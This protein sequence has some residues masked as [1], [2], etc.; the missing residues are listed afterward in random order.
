MRGDP[1]CGE[2]KLRRLRSPDFHPRLGPPGQSGSSTAGGQTTACTSGRAGG[3]SLRAKPPAQ[4]ATR[5]SRPAPD[6][7][8]HW[9]GCPGGPGA[10]LWLDQTPLH[11][12]LT[13]RRDCGLSAVRQCP[14]SSGPPTFWR[15]GGRPAQPPRGVPGLYYRGGNT[16]PPSRGGGAMRTAPGVGVRPSAASVAARGGLS[17]RRLRL[18]RAADDESSHR[19]PDGFIVSGCVSLRP[20]WR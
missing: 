6:A 15:R 4:R 1:A 7:A 17:R 13:C 14:G 3:E 5:S 12:V 11:P 2:G 9:G 19:N 18:R 8:D 16:F 20:S 10:G